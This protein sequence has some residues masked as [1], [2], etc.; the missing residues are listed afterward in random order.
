MFAAKVIDVVVEGRLN[1]APFLSVQELPVE[2][3]TQLQTK[4][5]PERALELGLTSGSATVAAKVSAF[6]VDAV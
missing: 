4:V 1:A 2:L 3:L 5:I 6:I